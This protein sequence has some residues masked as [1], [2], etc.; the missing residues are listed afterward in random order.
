MKPQRPARDA[1][2]ELYAEVGR[3][4]LTCMGREHLAGRADVRAR[5]ATRWA[6]LLAWTCIGGALLLSAGFC[7]WL[8][9]MARHTGQSLSAVRDQAIEAYQAEEAE[10]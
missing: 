10:R 5:Y 2:K 9:L 1:F 3:E 8:L 4:E 7:A 6:W